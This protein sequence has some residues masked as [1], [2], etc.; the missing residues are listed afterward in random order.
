MAAER[1]ALLALAAA[2]AAVML[3]A[4]AH[5]QLAPSADNGGPSL[6]QPAARPAAAKPAGNNGG[7]SDPQ[8]PLN[9][10]NTTQMLQTMAGPKASLTPAFAKCDASD[11]TL[12]QPGQALVA[13]QINI[14]N[15]G[16]GKCPA[17][18]KNVR[19]PSNMLDALP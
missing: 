19:V 17:V 12:G 5:A 14:I 10:A 9:V 13:N 3:P 2:G 1:R 4:A 18:G 8:V 16:E 6:I 7:Q 11:L 15:T